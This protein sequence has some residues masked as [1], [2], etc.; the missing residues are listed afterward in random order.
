MTAS[1]VITDVCNTI[2]LCIFIESTIAMRSFIFM[3]YKIM[4]LFK[5]NLPQESNPV[6]LGTIILGRASTSTGSA[7][8]S[9]M[10]YPKFHSCMNAS[11]VSA[12]QL[13]R[14]ALI[15]IRKTRHIC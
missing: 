4:F 15:F 7:C 3:V 9:G 5:K 11:T 14:H 12:C 13:V 10:R 8:L 1:S 2:L 6:M